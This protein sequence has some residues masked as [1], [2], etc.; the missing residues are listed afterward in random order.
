MLDRLKVIAGIAAAAFLFARACGPSLM[1]AQIPVLPLPV[2]VYTVTDAA[3]FPSL[4]LPRHALVFHNGSFASPGVD[5]TSVAGTAFVFTAALS[6]GD[7]IEVV[8]LP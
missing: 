2:R 1:P 7:Q 8:T 6:N 4:P 5:Y 3:T